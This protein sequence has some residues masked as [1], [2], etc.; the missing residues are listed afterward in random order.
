M[1]TRLKADMVRNFVYNGTF[2]K[3]Y[4]HRY[5]QL[6]TSRVEYYPN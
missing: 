3:I 6:T 4:N 2:G 5:S 1:L